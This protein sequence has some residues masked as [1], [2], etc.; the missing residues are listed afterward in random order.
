MTRQ[1]A[2]QRG[3]KAAA[4]R[5]ATELRT[6]IGLGALEAFDPYA[7]AELYGV[8]V[9]RLSEIDCSP[10][11]FEYFTRTRTEVFS[12]ALVPTGT[13]SVILE[14]DAHPVVRRRSTASHEMAHVVLEHRFAG[15]LVNE[16]GCRTA[17]PQQEAEASELAGE[18]LLP[19]AAAEALARRRASD[20]EAGSQFGVSTAFA[21]WR[22]DS[23]G[24][25]VIARRRTAAYARRVGR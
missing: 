17:D 9:L 23:T 1:T 19:F 4:K 22:L 18:L 24:A 25:R 5:L 14:N 2:L 21:R 12:G 10:A 11:A 13:G 20:D 16:R 8:D 7:L 6:E 15:S 3:F